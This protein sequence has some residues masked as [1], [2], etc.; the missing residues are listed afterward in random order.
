M[1]LEIIVPDNLSEIT[2]EQYQKYLKIQEENSNDKFLAS[3]MIEIFCNLKLSDTLKMKF[4]DVDAI[5][6]ILADMLNS[7][8]ELV[9]TFKMNGVEYGFIPK[10]DDIS[11]GEYVDLDTFLGDWE[12]MHRAM[13]VLYRPIE[14]KYGDKYSIVEYDAGD[15]EM[16]KHMPL[17]AV[18]SSIVFFLPFRDR[19]VASYD[20]LFGGG[21]GEQFSAISQFAGKW[22][23]YQSIYA[24][25]QGDI[26]RFED[27]TKLNVHKCFMMLTFEKEKADIEASRL[28]SKMK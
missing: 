19:L 26:R 14:Q 7:K 28:K 21:T 11:L 22:G 20:E 17:D 12:N 6:N 9:K 8:P 10:L 24:L 5:C 1:K 3:K 13:A 2:L 18:I 25:S 23:W 27:I 16:M 15:G 4:S